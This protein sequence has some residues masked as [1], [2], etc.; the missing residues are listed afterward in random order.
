[1]IHTDQWIQAEMTI[2]IVPKVNDVVKLKNPLRESFWVIIRAIH[3]N[4]MVGQVDNHLIKDSAYNYGDFVF[5]S[6]KDI[7]DHKSVDQQKQYLP[8]I[9][10]VL[11]TLSRQGVLTDLT[12]DEIVKIVDHYLLVKNK[13]D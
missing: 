5:F 1:M 8:M 3:N 2:K 7:R 10:E 4:V 12:S 6:K 11:D 13:I 9:N